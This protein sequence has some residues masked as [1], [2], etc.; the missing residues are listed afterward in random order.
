[1]DI[2]K[3][4]LNILKGQ[5]LL[6]SFIIFAGTYALLL[7][8]NPKLA[9][10]DDFIFLRTLQAGNPILYYSQNFP[11]Y[12]AATMGRFTPLAAMEYNLFG[13]FFKSPNP[14][15]YFLYHSAQLILISFFIVKIFSQ[16]TENKVI[17]YGAPVLLFLTPGFAISW[18]RMQMNERNII[19][20]LAA[21]LYFYLN[22]IKNKKIA[23]LILGLISANLAIYYKETAFIAI[24]IFAFFHFIFSFN[25][26]N[27]KTKIFD[28]LLI[29]SSSVY[30]IFYYFYAYISRG[31]NIYGSAAFNW[32]SFI[33]NI[34]NYALFSD[35]ILILILLPLTL[36][37]LFKIIFRNER[38]EP[39]IDS[40]LISAS[41]YIA[42]FFVLNMY[43]PYYLLPA[44]IL[45]LPALIYFLNH[46][47]PKII[48]WKLL[49]TITA[50]L[51]V[52]NVIPS[53]LHYITYYKYLPINFNN[54]LDFMVK[55]MALKHSSSQVNIFMDGIDRGTGRGTYFVLAEFLR[56]KGLSDNK[57]DL[58]SNVKTETPLPLIS[59]IPVPFT[60]FESD[61][62][63]E[64]KTGDYLIVSPQSTKVN[65]TDDYL[66]S[67]D[68]D[69][70]LVFQTKSAF[71]F[72]QFNLKTLA[73][74]LLS[75]KITKNRESYNVIVN[76]NL[77][78]QP[79]YYVFIKK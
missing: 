61:V 23:Y 79:D 53:G 64:I 26:E 59:K 40:L 47:Q 41:V 22:Q 63:D 75:Q 69:Y 12:D 78:E 39:I 28:G 20:F 56:F 73:K 8:V 65:I 71:A 4:T 27:L 3:K 21:F 60:V 6:T 9:P 11:Y 54:A 29:F 25:A 37:R 62:I 2:F 52:V 48:F 49:G 33:K 72:P 15:W 24:G 76:E 14:F 42:A 46:H 43:G 67:L 10:T 51:F 38:I 58:K 17:I 1:M 7:L 32:I 36:W 55:N 66:S 57:F 77:M 35:P 70:D 5:F 34:L 30:L 74:Y 18:F 45:A 50:L 16:F 68:Q 31:A 13:I 19:F 44:Y